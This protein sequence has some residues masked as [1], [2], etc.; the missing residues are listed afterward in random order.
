MTA[1][2]A[3]TLK[4]DSPTGLS[5]PRIRLHGCRALGREVVVV[6]AAA[7]GG[8]VTAVGGTGVGA[9]AASGVAAPADE[10]AF[11]LATATLSLDDGFAVAS[12]PAAVSP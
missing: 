11:A 9:R 7:V 2:C 8:A 10:I 6:G 1:V 3:R 4:D 12:A 5:C